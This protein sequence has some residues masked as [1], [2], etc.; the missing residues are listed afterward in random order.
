VTPPSLRFA[1]LLMAL[2]WRQRIAQY[3]WPNVIDPVLIDPALADTRAELAASGPAPTR[4]FGLAL[5]VRADP[6]RRHDTLRRAVDDPEPQIAR[7]AIEESRRVS[8]ALFDELTRRLLAHPRA[9]LRAQALRELN[10]AGLAGMREL[11]EARLFDVSRSPRNAAAFLLRQ[12][13][14]VDPLTHWR[15]A[16]DA[17]Q[18]TMARIALHALADFATPEDAPRSRSWLAHPSGTTRAAAL[19]VLARARAPDLVAEAQRALA[20]PSGKV[21]REALAIACDEPA[22]LSEPVLRDCYVRAAD[23]AARNRLITATRRLD[24]WTALVML[25]DWR[26]EAE[27]ATAVQ[28]DDELLNWRRYDLRRFT[29]LD[30]GH[31]ERIVVALTALRSKTSPQTCGFLEHVLEHA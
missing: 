15:A 29:P 21:V 14:G 1:D 7:W 26:A 17:G 4:L 16:L 13:L 28:L 27:G 25:L 11:L 18:G 22:V 3:A 6:D 9:Q 20:D 24:K 30:A 8:P 10:V 19:R 23:A 2:R 5:I 31:R 12:R